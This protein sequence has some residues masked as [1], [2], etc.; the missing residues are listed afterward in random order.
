MYAGT[1]RVVT[2][3]QMD[4]ES[5]W[6]IMDEVGSSIKHSDKPNVALFPFVYS[7]DCK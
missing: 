4:E 1:Y 5:A 2:E 7:P 6:Y 3:E